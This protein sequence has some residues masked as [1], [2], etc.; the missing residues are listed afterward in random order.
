M[1]KIIDGK[2]IASELRE[3]LSVRNE[4]LK[5][6]GIVPGL[7]TILVG[8]NPASKLYVNMK[9]KA[10]SAVGINSREYTFPENTGTGKILELIEG[11]N[12][13]P[14]INGILVQLPLPASVEE[15]RVLL[16]ID[17]SKD[18]DGF[19]PMNTGRLYS[20]KSLSEIEK[21][22]IFLP[23]TPW[24]IM[25]LL[26]SAGIPISGSNA[27]VVGR[28]NIVGKP[29]AMLLLS[30]NATVTMCHSRTKDLGEVTNK[31]DILIAAIGSPKMITGEM[32]KKGAVII[33]VGSNK[34]DEGVV[35]DVDFENV[36]DK[37]AA[38]TPVPGGVGP[39]TITMLLAN[40]VKSAE[41]AA[42]L[43]SN[44]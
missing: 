12:A 44:E 2:K 11:L 41:I 22:N 1:N 43:K 18:V 10:C 5:K 3:N 25:H 36:V 27:V 39:M 9:Q 42:G 29:A 23:C 31:A 34:T 15:D 14:E 40:T 37:V 13:D 32:V 20:K 35:G 33:D 19:H 8:E 16:A 28:S 26:K 38:I 7:A 4:N 30:S 24:G 6:Q 17:P 21:D